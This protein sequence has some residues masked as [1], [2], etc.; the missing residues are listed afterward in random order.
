MTLS[1]GLS[2]PLRPGLCHFCIPGLGLAGNHR[3]RLRVQLLDTFTP[4]AWLPDAQVVTDPGD[5]LAVTVDPRRGEVPTP[6]VVL[7]DE[8]VDLVHRVL[9]GLDGHPALCNAHCGLVSALAEVQVRHCFQFDGE[10]CGGGLRRALFVEMGRPGVVVIQD[11]PLRLVEA[12]LKV[13]SLFPDKLHLLV[14]V[15]LQPIFNGAR[16]RRSRNTARQ[17]H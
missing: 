14:G 5:F 17:R 9:Q 8:G 4:V 13:C 6:E 10:A 2:L 16:G 12:P 11:V 1:L 7:L 15:L 3:P